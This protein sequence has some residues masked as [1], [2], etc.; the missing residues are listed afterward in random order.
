MKKQKRS[1]SD[2]T[3]YKTEAP[4][5]KKVK[6]WLETQKDIVFYK[7]SD[8]YHKGISDFVLCVR[9]IFVGLELKKRDGVVSPHQVLFIRQINDNGGV[10]GVVLCLADAKELVEKAR[11]RANETL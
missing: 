9:G 11:A 8:R 1:Q 5:T 7:A 3:T 10:A 4:L 2:L 6:E